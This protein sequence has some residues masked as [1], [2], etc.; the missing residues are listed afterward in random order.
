[1][2]TWGNRNPQGLT[3][4]PGTGRAIEVEHGDD[5][6]DEINVLRLGAN[7]GYPIYPR[8]VNRPGYVDPAWSSGNVTLAT[9]GGAFLKGAQWGAWSGS[10]VVATLKEQDLR[11]FEL[12]DAT[13]RQADILFDNAWGRLRTPRLAPDGSLYLTTDNGAN[14]RVLAWSPQL[15]T[16]RLTQGAAPPI[17]VCSAVSW[18]SQASMSQNVSSY[19]ADTRSSRATYGRASARSTSSAATAPVICSSR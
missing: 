11:R 12:F 4:E 9:S 6:H 10:L 13:A 19:A 18:A 7:Y 3:F 14:D 15:N 1:M 5:T 8:P 16:P 2:F 17:Y